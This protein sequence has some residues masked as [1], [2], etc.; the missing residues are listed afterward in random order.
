M[1][2]LGNFKKKVKKINVLP[3][4]S[5]DKEKTLMKEYSFR[6]GNESELSIF[7]KVIA[8]SPDEAVDIANEEISSEDYPYPTIDYGLQIR[9]AYMEVN[10]NFCVDKSMIIEENEIS[11]D[12]LLKACEY[13]EKQGYRYAKGP[14]KEE[15]WHDQDPLFEKSIYTEDSEKVF[16][17]FEVNAHYDLN[18]EGYIFQ[19]T[20]KLYPKGLS[21]NKDRDEDELNDYSVHLA[22]QQLWTTIDKL[23]TV[24]PFYENKFLTLIQAIMKTDP[25]N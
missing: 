24:L 21:I 14:N 18:I 7:F 9:D 13:L 3:I 23:P 1:G 4:K 19:I 22:D 5:A 2:N 11:I 20:A 6:V 15:L 16:A 12:T 25:C 17:F 10:P 8:K